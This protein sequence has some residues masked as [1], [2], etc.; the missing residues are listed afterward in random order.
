M[1]EL[2]FWK[3]KLVQFFHDPAAKPF[4][5]YPGSG[6]HAK[7]AADMF[8][9][10]TQQTLRFYNRFPD[11]AASGADRPMLAQPKGNSQVQLGWAKRPVLTHPLWPAQ[12]VVDVSR[13]DPG[14]EVSINDELLNAQLEALDKLAGEAEAEDRLADW[15]N[16]ASLQRDFR[17]LWRRF[18]D[19]LVAS[20]AG[21]LLWEEMPSETRCPDHSIWDH[22]RVTTALAFL[23]HRSKSVSDAPDPQ[24]PWLLR[25]SLHPVQRFIQEARTSRDL[26]VAS[27]LLSDLIWH[28][29]QPI[30]RRYGHDCIVYPDLRG[31]PLVDNW[32]E[33]DDPECLSDAAKGAA[34]FASLLPATFTAIVPRG[35][36]GGFLLPLEE[37]A[38]QC[39]AAVEARWQA[40]AT[41]VETWLAAQPGVGTGYWQEIWR[42]QHH[43]PETQ[44]PGVPGATVIGSTW[45]AVAWLPPEKLKYAASLR[46][47]ALPGQHPDFRSQLNP[48]DLA[49]IAQRKARLAPWLPA[50]TWHHY[51]GAR[52]VFAHT[53]LNWHQM[54]R[55]FD[56]ALTH[57]QL[58]SRHAL[59]HAQVRAEGLDLDEPGEKCT[60][61]GRRQAL[62]GQRT[63]S[64][65]ADRQAARAFWQNKALDPEESGAER[66][67]AVCAMKRFLVPAGK[68]KN[69]QLSGINPVWA[70]R[71]LAPEAIL[72]RDGEPRVP[73]PSTAT[74]AAQ[75]FIEAVAARAELAPLIR[76][77]ANAH[78]TAGL[79][80]TSFPRSLPRLAAV[81]AAQSEVRGFLTREPEEVLFPEAI[82]GQ[83]RGYEAKGK[84]GKAEGL[85]NLA[86]KVAALRKRAGELGIAAPGK[87]IAVLKMDGDH[88]GRLLLGDE[89]II[90]TTWRDVLHP[91]A[92]RQM[93]ELTDKPRTHLHEAGWLDL[94]DAR[95][96]IGPSLHAY[97]SRALASFSHRIVPWVVEQ[98]F[99]GRLIYAG[100]DD[101]LCL[102]PGDEALA[103]AARLQQLFSAPW[104]VDTQ[105]DMANQ[106]EWRRPNW[107][108]RYDQDQ[109]R[110]RFALPI[111]RPQQPV[112]LPITEKAA[113]HP[114]VAGF[115]GGEMLYPNLPVQ[116][117]VLPML[118][119]GHSLSAGIAFGHYKT[120]LSQL[121]ARAGRMLDEA[122]EH[123]GRSAVALSHAARGGEKNVFAMNWGSGESGAYTV[124]NQVIQGFKQGHLPNRLPYKLRELA[125]LLRALP[126]D[127]E[128]RSPWLHGLFK[129]ALGETV[130][131]SL[132]NAAFTLWQQGLHLAAMA[133]ERR[134]DSE[135][136]ESV[137][138]QVAGLLL[139]RALAASEEDAE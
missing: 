57:H 32:L 112:S 68:D 86:R 84:P 37:L 67:C 79:T 17:R 114:H 6:G 55:G 54:E 95:R 76:E 56:Y 133:D 107:K 19:E 73:F 42:R 89:K 61:C 16:P 7:I 138:R 26:W 44:K 20:R 102:V 127:E 90:K 80:P 34:S 126:E 101:L 122:K 120:P 70:G 72:D 125:P 59:R 118:G 25:F 8:R 47:R 10:F 103:L 85:R 111:F 110:R 50:T 28:G 113:L 123:A 49:Q 119:P 128:K 21:N 11:W 105:A 109:A 3:Q 60:C 30:V 94:L 106:W 117:P 121:L 93:T 46:G 137:E 97:I 52:E 63:A 124:L 71:K 115:S 135:Q 66:L 51:E 62:T 22:L 24:C 31:N 12:W 33:A 9:R 87:R 41:T 77:V 5:S 1:D 100:G 130:S 88:L 129:R 139:C 104:I 116:G 81:I 29:M 13:A 48:Q 65:V 134:D 18:R 39:Q 75:G 74:I 83:A 132:E 14:S 92:V 38:A 99:S 27:F 78:Q 64:L 23:P 2:S 82:E 40:L 15:Q 36:A 53:H 45:S 91:E 96:L 69:G 108:G 58:V 98:E 35:E 131:V 4:A 136:A 43:Y